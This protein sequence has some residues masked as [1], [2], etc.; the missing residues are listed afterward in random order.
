MS[1]TI[2]IYCNVPESILIYTF[3]ASENPNTPKQYRLSKFED[4]HL[5]TPMAHLLKV[6][7]FTST[8][9]PY[10]NFSSL[11]YDWSLSE[12]VPSPSE[13]NQGGS[14]VPRRDLKSI[15]SLSVVKQA[16]DNF[17]VCALCLDAFAQLLLN[18]VAQA[19]LVVRVDAL[20]FKPEFSSLKLEH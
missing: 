8:K 9:E 16:A 17:D 11:H 2:E 15:A 20:A 13:G 3:P 7:A 14:G 1:T 5:R 18:G 10:Y 4:L 19:D 12:R 6:W